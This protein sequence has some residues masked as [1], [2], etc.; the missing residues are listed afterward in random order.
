MASASVYAYAVLGG[1]FDGILKGSIY[2]LM[3]LGLTLIMRVAKFANFAYAEYV[4]YAAYA[5]ALSSALLAGSPAAFL[6]ALI[7]AIVVGAV[8]S[9]VSDEVVFKPLWRRGADALT[10]LVAS[11][12]VDLFMRYGLLAGLYF[13]NR[14]DLLDVTV[15][16]PKAEWCTGGVACFG[17]AGAAALLLALGIGGLL[18]YMFTR[19][20]LGKAMRATASNPTLARI[21]GIDIYQVRRVTW[22]LAGAIAGIAGLVYA[23]HTTVNVESGWAALLWMFAAAIMGGFTFY[24][25][26]VS[27]FILGFIEALVGQLLNLT[28]IAGTQYSPVIALLALVLVLLYRP[29]GVIRLETHMLRRRA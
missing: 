19:T 2:G 12:G 27:G 11:I 9:L 8:V 20:R 16:A 25:A 4:T 21:T 29:E 7:A 1:F 10:L 13:S 6:I 22:L 26:L 18:H 28:G 14:T 17:T 3:A 23:Y 5:A 15:E 24:G